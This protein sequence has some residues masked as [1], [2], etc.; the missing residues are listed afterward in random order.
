MT[1]VGFLRAPCSRNRPSRLRASFAWGC[2]RLSW[3]T[4]S[5]EPTLGARPASSRDRVLRYLNSRQ[6]ALILLF[7]AAAF[8]LRVAV[9]HWGPDHFWSYTAYY[10]LASV[11][12]Q[13]G[14]YCM[15]PR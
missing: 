4:V 6:R 12:T 11:V 14:G 9:A 15:T 10:D 2:W 7:C 8:L 1:R 3:K 5:T 13:G